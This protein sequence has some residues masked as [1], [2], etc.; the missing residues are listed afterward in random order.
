ENSTRT[1][2]VGG[3]DVSKMI[4]CLS[5]STGIDSPRAPG[6]YHQAGRH[7]CLPV[8]FTFRGE[9]AT[10]PLLIKGAQNNE[11]LAGTFTFFRNNIVEGVT[12]QHSTIQLIDGRICNVR[13]E[14]PSVLDAESAALPMLIHVTCVY[15]T[16]VFENV[17]GKAHQVSW[18]ENA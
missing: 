16:I 10:L 5:F 1:P 8:E 13:F 3:E 6:G 9:G 14:C 18:G 4:E 11:Q 17:E 2:T 12:E 7:V 15:H